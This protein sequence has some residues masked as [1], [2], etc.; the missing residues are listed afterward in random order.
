[1]GS[2]DYSSWIGLSS[3]QVETVEQA[4]AYLEGSSHEEKLEKFR[5]LKVKDQSLKS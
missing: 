4:L 5:C 3:D 1:M 2:C